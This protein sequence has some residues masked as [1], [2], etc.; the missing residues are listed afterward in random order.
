RLAQDLAGVVQGDDDNQVEEQLQPGR[1][2][3]RVEISQVLHGAIV[4][5]RVR[6]LVGS[7]TLRSSRREESARR[8]RERTDARAPWWRGVIL[9]AGAATSFG[10]ARPLTANAS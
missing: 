9:G 10:H 4:C 6:P 8:V 3:V 7:T 5:L 1:A 2:P